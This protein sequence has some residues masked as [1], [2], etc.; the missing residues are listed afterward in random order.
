MPA[1]ECF[2]DFRQLPWITGSN[3]VTSKPIWPEVVLTRINK[4][5]G[6]DS[7]RRQTG[8]ERPGRKVRVIRKLRGI[9]YYLHVKTKRL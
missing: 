7:R 2:R 5:K 6:R 8:R 9:S 4:D 3:V 1:D